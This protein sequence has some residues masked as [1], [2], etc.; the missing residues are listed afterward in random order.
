M[1]YLNRRK[2]LISKIEDG[3][4]I[5]FSGRKILKSADEA[6]PFEVDKN[7]Y[8]LTGLDQ[9]E[10]YLIMSKNNERIFTLPNDENLARWVGYNFTIEEVKNISSCEDVETNENI[11]NVLNKIALENKHIYLDLT[12][13]SF[14][15]G[16]N[17]GERLKK[18]LLSKNSNLVIEDISKEI[19]ALRAVKDQDEINA[20]RHSILITKL[21]LEEVMKKMK[22]FTNEKEAQAFFEERIASLGHARTSFPTIAA[23]GFNAT[24]LHYSDNNQQ[25]NNEDMILMDLGACINYYNADITRTYPH[26][27]KYNELQKTI[28]NIVLNCNKKIINLIKPGITIKF[29]QDQT[30][31]ILYEGLK[32]NDLIEN[33]D[34]LI[35]YYFHNISHHLGLDT[36]DP[37]ARLV[38]LQEGNVI[39]VEPGL[40]IRKLGI[41]I[42]IEDDVLVTSTGSENLS[43]DIIKEIDDIEAFMKE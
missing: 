6:Y 22:S 5:L 16:I 23:A 37:M 4:I 7:F 14:L 42:R 28:Y 32:R 12:E 8:Y 41:G 11:E 43:K 17:Q 2:K 24:I 26:L 38:P 34:E 39:T 21:A 36:H 19:L 35:E 1:D 15:G 13:S 3:I 29:L 27:G 10:T 25:F 18:L 40:Y 20:L 31:K 9:D 30:K 33:E